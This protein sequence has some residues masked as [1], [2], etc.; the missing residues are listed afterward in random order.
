MQRRRTFTTRRRKCRSAPTSSRLGLRRSPGVGAPIDPNSG[1]KPGWDLA[2]LS[3]P[4]PSYCDLRTH[5]SGPS[6]RDVGAYRLAHKAHDEVGSIQ[7]SEIT[8]PRARSETAV[9]PPIFQSRA[10][11]VQLARARSVA[12]ESAASATR[13]LPIKLYADMIAR[14][15]H[16]PAW[17]PGIEYR[18][19]AAAIGSES[20]YWTE[21]QCA[22][23][24]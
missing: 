1:S 19:P 7:V 14:L 6:Q 12:M 22:Q 8:R 2:A 18:L 11:G 4:S 16:F 23:G 20:T 10:L 24:H 21:S 17:I 13:L 9:G 15:A 3:C 5:R